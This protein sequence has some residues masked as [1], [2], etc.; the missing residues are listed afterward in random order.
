MRTP[1]N[2]DERYCS[3][4]TRVALFVGLVLASTDFVWLSQGSQNPKLASVKTSK[5]PEES[6]KPSKPSPEDLFKRRY[7]KV[8]L[9]TLQDC[10]DA[11]L[12][13]RQTQD[14]HRG[15]RDQAW[16]SLQK[17]ESQRTELR[18][19]IRRAR[20]SAD[21]DNAELTQQAQ[22]LEEAY[23]RIDNQTKR[24]TKLLSELE[25]KCRDAGNSHR[26][27]TKEFDEADRRVRK[28][29]D[30]TKYVQC[31]R[32][33]LERTGKKRE[34]ELEAA[35][36]RKP[37]AASD[38]HKRRPVRSP[39]SS[40]SNKST[41]SSRHS[42]KR[43]ASPAK[44]DKLAAQSNSATLKAAI[45]QLSEE[46]QAEFQ[47]FKQWQARKKARSAEAALVAAL[48]PTKP[49]DVGPAKFTGPEPVKPEE[50]AQN[51]KKPT[52]KLKIKPPKPPVTTEQASGQPA[53]KKVKKKAQLV[54]APSAPAIS[55]HP[56]PA[57]E[58]PKA[59]QNAEAAALEAANLQTPE[60]ITSDLEFVYQVRESE[61]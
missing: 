9:K 56:E 32:E 4:V 47:D 61:C 22:K 57:K 25:E 39:P 13:I 8:Y 59:Q 14:K 49:V 50:P 27:A 54:D 16:K 60:E 35:K 43:S 1:G 29:D 17:A 10:R 33:G 52:L 26:F 20:K 18:E 41:S 6:P 42:R 34:Q 7:P 5:R 38:R 21:Q 48:E 36:V 58:K 11:H 31:E 51:S 23:K 2:I 40:S 15:A 24:S 28:G 3:V 53:P 44:E 45:A 30:D 55:D 46:E 19:E 37:D 12:L